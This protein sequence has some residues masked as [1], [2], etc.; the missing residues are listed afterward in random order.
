MI[1][2]IKDKLYT[3]DEYGTVFPDLDAKLTHSEEKWVAKH[4]HVNTDLHAT[5]VNCQIRH[6]LKY[7]KLVEKGE[8]AFQVPCVGIL[9]KAPASAA[10]ILK[11]LEAKAEI[12]PDRAKKLVMSLYDPVVWAEM[13]FG[14]SDDNKKWHIRK[15]QKEALR[16]SSQRMVLV[17]G[18]RAGKS[19]VAA[20]KLLY[21]SQHV[22]KSTFDEEGKEKKVGPE[23]MIITPF[24]SQLLN[25]FNELEKLVKSSSSLMQQ[26]SSS[27]SSGSL[28]TKT[29][30]FLMRFA[31]GSTIKGFV[32]GTG[33]RADS[34]DGGTIR[35]ASADVIYVDEMDMIP[36]DILDRVI[37]PILLTNPEGVYLIGTST[38]IGKRGRF[39]HWAKQTP[40]FKELHIPSTVLPQ[41]ENIKREVE[42]TSTKDVFEAEYL[43]KF[44][45]GMYGVFRPSY[46]VEAMR[47]YSYLGSP[48]LAQL[49]QL[50]IKE[51][52]QL[53]KVIGIDWNK[54][55]GSEFYVIGFDP[56][57]GYLWGLDAVN[58]A[59]SDFSSEA[60]KEEVIRLNYVWKPDF[61]YAD[62]GYGHTVIEDLKLISHQLRGR[63][64]KDPRDAQTLKLYDRLVA[65]NFSQKVELR[66]PIDGGVINKSGKE[67]LVENAVR[68]F[69]TGRFRFSRSDIP[70]NQ[71][72]LN[73]IELRRSP[74]TNKPVYGASS[75][76]IGDH[77]LDAM[78]LA[79]AAVALEYSAYSK[80]MLPLSAPALI[81]RE[82]LEK[83]HQGADG[84]PA[85]LKAIEELKRAQF[86]GRVDLLHLAKGDYSDEI[87]V[88]HTRTTFADVVQQS[89]GARKRGL[90]PRG[91]SI[92]RRGKK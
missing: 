55:A 64:T 16:C 33:A 53:V 6:K 73:Y 63:P 75:P 65:F 35:G 43:A 83:R 14:F 70:L 15:H 48:D 74:T 26:I 10:K 46:I 13:N 3:T 69:E 21:L 54:N 11:Q 86:P 60:W 67:F 91:R 76:K 61:I 68:M 66:N 19:F 88:K 31:N 36:D 39:Y 25:I 87:P 51:P 62:E 22:L 92:K 8:E 40:A 2:K 50:G 32:S 20:L 71:Q 57:T 37:M 78:M 23:V 77:R 47:D 5:C 81:H 58:V 79:M 34:S 27:S 89:R 7:E 45:E 42:G 82:V 24:Q 85:E 52:S 28:Y 44:V 49:M 90:N 18:R 1:E 9:K 30:H 41:W 17:W 59:A 56:M 84:L 29:P 12:P 4:M 38:P 80:N 72:L